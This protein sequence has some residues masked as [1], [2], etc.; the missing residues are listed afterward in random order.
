MSRGLRLGFFIFF[1]M[2][3]FFAGIFLIGENQLLFSPS[4]RL[5]ASFNNVAGLLVGAE[6]RVGG[7]RNGTVDRIDMPGQPGDKVIV[8]M[9]VESSTR[10]IIKKDSVASIETEG[11]LGNKY[12]AISF[13]SKEGEPVRDG[14]TIEGQPALDLSD[15]IKKTNEIADSTRNT[16]RNLEGA[17]ADLSSI[18]SRINRGEGTIGALVNDKTVYKQ[19]RATA[20]GMRDTVEQAKIGVTAFQ[21]DMQALKHNFFFRGF[22]KNRGYQDSTELTKNEIARLPESTPLKRFIFVARDL[23]DKPDTAKLKGMQSLNQVGEFLEQSSFGLAVVVASTGLKGKKSE[24]LVLSKGRATVVRDYLARNYKFDD[25]RLKTKGMG[26][27]SAAD[28]GAGSLEIL[29]YPEQAVV[30][31][32]KRTR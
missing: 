1:A 8:V 20:S 25:T 18:T 32:N 2:V 7:V 5:K 9:N 29:V 17:T 26:E 4:F 13:G 14:D 16:M 31:A 10:R 23:F 30:L 28:G 21:E 15:I 22:F 3:F 6:V 19:F 11:L 24:N 27:D 12:V